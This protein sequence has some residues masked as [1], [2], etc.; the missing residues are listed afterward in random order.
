MAISQIEAAENQTRFPL[1]SNEPAHRSRHLVRIDQRPEQD[2]GVEQIVH[3][4][5]ASNIF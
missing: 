3:R 1:S 5:S 2:V 4:R